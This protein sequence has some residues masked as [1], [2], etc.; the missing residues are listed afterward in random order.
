MKV[1]V[2]PEVLQATKMIAG[3]DEVLYSGVDAHRTATH[4][5]IM[6]DAGKVLT[7]KRVSSS[8]DGLRSLFANYNEPIKAVVERPI[9][10]APCTTGW[11]KSPMR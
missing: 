4:I 6:D 10:G 2:H 7:R 1:P 11:T 5:T 8:P 9:T 3:V